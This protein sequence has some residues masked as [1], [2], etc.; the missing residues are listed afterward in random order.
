MDIT[1]VMKGQAEYG[2]D[3]ALGE[4]P[5]PA[6]SRGSREAG[7]LRNANLD[8]ERDPANLSRLHGP[9]ANDTASQDFALDVLDLD[10]DGVFPLPAVSR[11]AND[12][13]DAERAEDRRRRRLRGHPDAESPL[14]PRADPRTRKHLLPAVGA[15]PGL[16]R[17]GH[18]GS[19]AGT[20]G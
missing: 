7:H 4:R 13:I 17:R 18:R 20:G 12:P 16:T 5:A 1:G 11:M 8:P 10:Q 14:T 15:A 3:H 19:P 9:D 6:P 2:Q